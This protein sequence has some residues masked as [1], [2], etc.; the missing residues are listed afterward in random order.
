MLLE[1]GPG[2]ALTRLARQH[3]AANAGHGVVASLGRAEEQLHDQASILNAL[4]RLWVSGLAVPGPGFY[5]QQRR[6]RLPLPTY[7]FEGKRYWVEPADLGESD[8]PVPRNA[9]SG[10]TMP[11][12]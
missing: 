5:A 4:S 6:H 7:P 11:P 2:Q 3:P 1:V 9:A 8:G 10:Q 12:T